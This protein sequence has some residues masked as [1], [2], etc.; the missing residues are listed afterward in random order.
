MTCNKYIQ[1]VSLIL[2]LLFI[3]TFSVSSL[4]ISETI[5]SIDEPHLKS[6]FDISQQLD[7]Q[8]ATFNQEVLSFVQ[9]SQDVGDVAVPSMDI[10]YYLGMSF[11]YL[12]RFGYKAPNDLVTEVLDFVNTSRNVDGGYGNWNGA[13]S[14]VESTFQALQLLV[15]YNNL[16][17]LSIDG[18]NQTVKFLEQ[19]KTIEQGYLPLP[20]WDAPD[21]SSTYRVIYGLEQID[22]EFPGI[23]SQLDN[24]S[25][26]FINNTFV[27]PIFVN[28]AS[29]FSETLGGPAELLASLY[30]VQAY[31]L[32]NITDTPYFASVAKLLNSLI[33]TNG[34]VAGY[35]GGLPTMGYTAAAMQLYHLFRTETSFAIDDYLPAT[36]LDDSLNYV[37]ANREAGSGFTA[38]ERDATAETS[39]SFFALRILSLLDEHGLLSTLP[40]L[41]G[42]FNYLVEG[43]QPTFGFANYPGD[44]SDISYTTQAILI[45]KLLSDSGYN[46]SGVRGYVESTYSDT[47]RGFG[48]RPGSSARVKY[49]HFGVRA[50]RGL[51]EPL[52]A[53]PN[54]IQYLLDSQNGDG[55]FG[56][57][58]GSTISYLTHTYWAVTTLHHLGD[59]ERFPMD[60]ES[61]LNWLTYLEKPDGTYSNFPGFNSTLTSTYRAMIVRSILNDDIDINGSLKTTLA[62]YQKIS[63]GFVSSL[64]RTVPTMESTFY[65]VAL[66]L[67][68]DIPLNVTHL[69]DFVLSLQNDDGGFGLRPGFSSRVESTF[70]ALLT[71]KLLNSDPESL[72]YADL[73]E[74][75]EDFYS[76]I[77]VPAFIPELE[78]Y[79]AFRNS[80]V[81]S[82]IVLEPESSL[83]QVWV[84]ADWIIDDTGTIEH[85]EFEGEPSE[86]YQNEWI[87]LMGTFDDDG[88]LRF[89]VHASDDN[90]NS[91]VTEIYFLTSLSE[92][93]PIVFPALNLI[94]VFLPLIL[95]ILFII[96]S[97]DGYSLHRR[98]RN[99]E[100]GDVKMTLKPKRRND[101]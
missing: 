56:E 10:A 92:T 39:S 60:T 83:V 16:S 96:S 68:F 24:S 86:I 32:M 3:S 80:Y 13:R 44:V 30:A 90:G 67:M 27:P 57:R 43:V 71:L 29:G 81:L 74:D 25:S 40:D 85:Y 59:I 64:D 26:G 21:V 70:Y 61:I 4:T 17:V 94:G 45:G 73:S 100:R 41:T 1:S 14:S 55:G 12:D 34:G 95:P 28:G 35:V 5:L 19:L 99:S 46:S 36:F 23:S 93:P 49:T 76:P 33:A 7:F 37:L 77:I 65:G 48:F 42:V 101:I 54:I 6:Q 69:L 53:T 91:A 8:N 63:G 98:K 87:F 38:S 20:Q 66:S 50:T 84:E 82:A 51:E 97:V 72:T 79:R 52:T 15:T 62:S 47:G 11:H 31:L 18:V 2:L 22:V 89:R 78:N 9:S 88:E 75:P 58:P